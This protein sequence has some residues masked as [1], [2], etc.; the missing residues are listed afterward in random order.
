MTLPPVEMHGGTR[1]FPKGTDIAVLQWCS[2]RGLT[3]D[4]LG[5]KIGVPRVSL[6][7]MLKGVDPVPTAVER[8]L[9]DFFSV[10]DPLNTKY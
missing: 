10:S 6:S 7:L 1:Y 4:V 5:T 3:L 9:R 8:K 2:A